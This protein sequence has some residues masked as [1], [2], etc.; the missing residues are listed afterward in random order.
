[1]DV[2]LADV[3]DAAERV[4]GV[5]I[6][7]PLREVHSL[8]A[9]SGRH[10]L[11]KME[12]IQRTGS[13]KIRG[14]YNKISRLDREELARGV[15]AASAGNHAQGVALA[16]S[17]VGARATIVMPQAAALPKV[18]ATRGYGAD[19]VLHG[20]TYDASYAHAREIERD[21]GLVYVHAF[22]DRHIVA[23]QGTVGLEILED[24]P[25][26]DLIAVPIGGGGLISG[27]ALAIKEQ[28]PDVRVVGVQAEGAAAIYESNRQGR[29]V[30][31]DRVRTI[32]DGLAIK[33]PEEL[34]L[35]LIA[36]YVDD[37]V[38][39]SEDEIAHAIMLMA[40]RAKAITEGAG[41]VTLAAVLAGRLPQART[42]ALVVSGGNIDMIQLARV[43]DHGLVEAGRYIRLTTTLIDR[44]GALRDFLAIVAEAGAN[45]IAAEHQRLRRGVGVGETDIDLTIETRDPDHAR[46]VLARLRGQGYHVATPDVEDPEIHT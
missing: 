7:T 39:V 40:E 26:V 6:R 8:D 41:A 2:T 27:I 5:A 22:N 33:K 44:P 29:P 31:L 43:I 3:R 1:M 18:M 25:E 10:L 30:Q 11:L 15:V 19:V 12:N 24:A 42:T 45:V 20:D 46:H 32:A 16:A 13:F 35:A 21:R 17:V 38:L 23:G 36:R 34:T 28:R 9:V 14:A 4:A 37:I